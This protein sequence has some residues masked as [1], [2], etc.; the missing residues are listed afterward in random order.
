MSSPKPVPI[1]D[2]QKFAFGAP[3]KSGHHIDHDVYVRGQGSKVLVLIQELPGIGKETLALADQFVAEGY[4]VYL[5]HLFGPI[6][7]TSVVANTIRVFCMTK[8]FSLFSANKS[9]PIVDWLKALCLKVKEDNNVKGVATIGMCLTGTFALALM[10]DDSVLASYASQPALP[11]F[12]QKGL[13]LSKDEIE[14]INS[15]LDDLEPMHCARFKKDKLCTAAKF[16]AINK[17]F[18]TDKKRVKLH[19]IPGKGHS[20]FTLDFDKGDG[21]PQEILQEVIAYFNRSLA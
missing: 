8:E 17:A 21:Q 18:N 11:I 15:R 4:R 5:P 3:I 16:A 14:Q 12:N 7:K 13:H 2:Y 1:T 20:V 10:A 19:E 6:G 9:S